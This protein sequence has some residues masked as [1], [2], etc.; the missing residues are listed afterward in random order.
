MNDKIIILLPAYKPTDGFVSLCREL[1]DNDLDVWVVDDGSGEV[2]RPFFDT[3]EEMGCFCVRHAVNLGKGRALKTGINAILNQEKDFYG[4]V[5]ADADGQHAVK[6]IL[7]VAE[8]MRSRPA[9]LVTGS[10]AFSKGDPL[11]SRI[12]NTITRFVY[13]F[14][15]GIMCRDT[16]T[17]LRGIPY[18]ALMNCLHIQGERFEYEM[19]MLLRLRDMRLS[20]HEVNI[21]TIYIDRNKGS[22]FKPFRDA[23]RICGAI[24]RFAFVSLLSY[25]VDYMFFV[26]FLN[27]IHFAPALSYAIARVI[28]S[29]F[30][31]SMNRVAVFGKR[32]G[33]A[34]I[35]R[36]YLLA[37]LLLLVGSGLVELL[38]SIFLYKA[39]WMKIPVDILL[40]FPSF[41]LQREFVFK[42]KR[43]ARDGANTQDA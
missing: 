2:F 30:N 21:E 34:S 14:V 5:T 25:G 11:K 22:H 4:L 43:S 18:G 10:R 37:A 9:S 15:M 23:L 28:S 29:C 42:D 1:R 13:Q 38:H 41:W 8:A 6:D 17:G 3:V 35:F 16:Q 24:F 19:N 31:Y 33:R 36:Y 26:F 12:G 20:L 40:F 32:G 27:T 7:R 39:A